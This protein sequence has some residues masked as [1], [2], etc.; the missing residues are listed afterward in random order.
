VTHSLLQGALAALAAHKDLIEEAYARGGVRR[1]VD[2]AREVMTLHQ[3]R[4]LVSDGQDEYHLSRTF[5]RF[6][7]DVTQRQRL[8]EALGE[9]IGALNDRIYNLKAEFATAV[10]ESRV[11]EMDIIAAQ[12]TDAC[13]DLSDAISTSL[14]RLLVQAESR[15]GVVASVAAKLRQNEHYLKQAERLSEAVSALSRIQDARWEIHNGDPIYADLT[16]P[17]HRLVAS[18]LG[19]WNAEILR[20]TSILKTFLFRLRQVAPDVSRL[21]AFADFLHHHPGYESPDFTDRRTLPAWALRDPGIQV[22]AHADVQ[23]ESIGPELE[24]IASKLPAPKVAVRRQREAGALTK[25][26]GHARKKLIVPPE[27]EAL[28]RFVLTAIGAA[29]PLS[30]RDWLRAGGGQVAIEEDI[31]LH[32]VLQARDSRVAPF[33][34]AVFQSVEYRGSAVISRNVFVRDVLVHGR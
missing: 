22:A 31:W 27:K 26:G 32:L 14:S 17:Y 20:V 12:F 15:F 33:D 16:G 6:L 23:D 13:A 2:N 29:A 25:S 5:S 9:N 24:A 1:N 8:Y 28:R 19:E 10:R 11:E 4:I 3:Y 30:A 18:R 34:K 21:R 7:D